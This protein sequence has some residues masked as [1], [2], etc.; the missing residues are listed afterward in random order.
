MKSSV[1]ALAILFGTFGAAFAEEA[2]NQPSEVVIEEAAMEVPA[3]Q[4]PEAPEAKE[5]Q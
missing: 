5:A 3:E 1:F 4:Q 2:A